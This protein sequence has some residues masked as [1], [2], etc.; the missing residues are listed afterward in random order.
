MQPGIAHLKRDL[1]ISMEGLQDKYSP[2]AVCFGCGPS[3]PKG[4]HIKSRPD[5]DTLVA[6][7]TPEPHHTAFSKFTN[8]G[9]I[10]VLLDCHG[11]MTAAYSLMKSRGLGSPPGTVTAELSVKFL[12]PTPLRS[13]LHLRAWV[14]KIEGDRVSVEGSVEAE[15]V[16][17]VSMRGLFVA[18][19]EGH[20]AFD[21][22]S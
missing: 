1:A 4:L 13:T 14:T 12:K 5:G 16:Q 2:N 17:T 9:I 3:N 7:W 15:G 18:V 21:K 11:N 8:G 19:K 20:P 6:D 22:W 10:S